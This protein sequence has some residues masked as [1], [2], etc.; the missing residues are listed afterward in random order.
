M[1]LKA[2]LVS[3]TKIKQKKAKQTAK[4]ILKKNNNNYKTITKQSQK[5]KQNKQKKTIDMQLYPPMM[6]L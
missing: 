4:V 1:T 5:Q 2:V 6:L 3:L